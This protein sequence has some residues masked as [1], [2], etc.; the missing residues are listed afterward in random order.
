M[1]NHVQKASKACA[2]VLALASW[3]S[4][5]EDLIYC[6]AIKGAKVTTALA[7]TTH[8]FVNNN[9]GHYSTSNTSWHIYKTLLK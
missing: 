5:I 9:D 1:C 7:T 2:A 3:C 8:F 4:H 6:C